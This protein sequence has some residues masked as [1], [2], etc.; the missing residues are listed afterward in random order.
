MEGGRED[1]EDTRRD[2]V[3]FRSNLS[4]ESILEAQQASRRAG[5]PSLLLSPPYLPLESQHNFRI[6]LAGS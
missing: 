5:R 6:V 1:G 3:L 2:S 4:P